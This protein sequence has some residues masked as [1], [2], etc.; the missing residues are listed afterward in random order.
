MSFFAM[1]LSSISALFCIYYF[2]Y[3]WLLNN[4]YPVTIAKCSETFGTI[5]MCNI[6]PIK[7]TKLD[8]MGKNLIFGLFL[9]R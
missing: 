2:Y 6:G 4:A 5:I 8:M 3:A 1:R 7:P 9:H